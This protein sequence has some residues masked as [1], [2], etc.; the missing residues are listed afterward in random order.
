VRKF[1]ELKPDVV[2]LD[3]AMPDMDGI[4]T[5]KLMSLDNPEVPIVLFTILGIEGLE[6][7]AKEAGISAIV[8]KNE[9]WSLLG[10]IESLVQPHGPH[11]AVAAPI[12]V[13]LADD[14]EMLRQA[15]RSLLSQETGIV[16][17]AEAVNYPELL[18]QLKET[19]PMLLWST[20]ICRGC[21]RPHP[22]ERNFG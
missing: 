17:V 8:P 9:A 20:F 4:E 11:W 3:L 15:I 6:P 5:A 19:K 14:S 10:S 22:S 18:K 21:G 16:L 7:L 12:R 13:L 1:H 2:V